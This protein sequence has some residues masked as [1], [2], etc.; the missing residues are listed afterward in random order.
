MIQLEILDMNIAKEKAHEN[1]T[2]Y[3]VKCRLIAGSFPMDSRPVWVYG[4]TKPTVKADLSYIPVHPRDISYVMVPEYRE[5]ETYVLY[6]MP[7]E[8]IF[9][10]MIISDIPPDDVH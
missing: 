5:T 1:V 6:V 2:V 8:E 9:A 7:G 4:V 10:G 3:L